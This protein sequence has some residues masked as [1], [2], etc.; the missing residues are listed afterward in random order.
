MSQAG[1]RFLVGAT[2]WVIAYGFARQEEKLVFAVL[3]VALG[4]AFYAV[5][6]A[7]VGAVVMGVVATSRSKGRSRFQTA[8][9]VVLALITVAVAST[10]ISLAIY[11]CSLPGMTT[12]N[13]V[14][15]FLNLCSDN[16]YDDAARYLQRHHEIATDRRAMIR[17]PALNAV[18]A[19]N[20]DP[21]VTQLLLDHGANP[22]V[23]DESGLTALDV[24]IT[25]DHLLVARLLLE[26]GARPGLWCEV[27]D[28]SELK[29][30]VE[31]RMAKEAPVHGR[32]NEQ[33]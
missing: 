32:T 30:I 12:E 20:Y 19:F 7:V 4:V 3:G 17:G 16:K 2:A 10:V 9:R 5:C 25:S 8:V 33:R 29:A 6:G 28:P 31:R 27:Q 24:A 22:N 11:W 23:T 15:V 13:H 1:W 14:F 18:A 21:R 26:R